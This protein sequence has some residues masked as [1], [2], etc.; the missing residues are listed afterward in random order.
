MS[1]SHRTKGGT[2]DEA[3]RS[4][5]FRGREEF[6]L[7][8]YLF[9][10]LQDILHS[11]KPESNTEEKEKINKLKSI[12][13][14]L[15]RKLWITLVLLAHLKSHRPDKI[16]IFGY[17]TDREKNAQLCNPSATSAPWRASW[18]YCYWYFR[19]ISWATDE[20]TEKGDVRFTRGRIWVIFANKGNHS[21]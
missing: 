2:S 6:L 17:A 5:V 1:Q 8:F 12:I 3:F 14:L 18:S 10:D 11:Q 13:G 19:A 16:N 9:L 15:S 21:P 4:S 7:D 20:G